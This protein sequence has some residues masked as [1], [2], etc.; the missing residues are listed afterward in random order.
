MKLAEQVAQHDHCELDQ[1]EQGG[2]PH[3]AAADLL[4]DPVAQARNRGERCHRLHR[5]ARS[6]TREPLSPT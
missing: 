3:Q 5:L 4:V 2:Q 6:Q 1:D